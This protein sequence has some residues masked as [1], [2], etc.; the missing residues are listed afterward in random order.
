M[1]LFDENGMPV[2]STVALTSDHFKYAGELMA[3]S[4]VQGGPAPNVLSPCFYDVVSK[5]LAYLKLTADMIGN[6][7]MKDIACKVKIV[8]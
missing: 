2:E 4:I 3:M 8:V 5:G 6:L 1:H 7:E